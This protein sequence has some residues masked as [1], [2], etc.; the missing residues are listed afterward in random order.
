M[1]KLAF[2]QTVLGTS[3]RFAKLLGQSIS[4]RSSRVRLRQI[5]LSLGY[6]KVQPQLKTAFFNEILSDQTVQLTT[7]NQEKWGSPSSS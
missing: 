2:A 3:G 5:G 4:D 1:S 6:I 7:L